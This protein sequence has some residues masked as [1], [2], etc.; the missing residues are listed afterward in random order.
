MRRVCA[1]SPQ[2]WVQ[3]QIQGLVQGWVQGSGSGVGPGVGHRGSDLTV[4]TKQGDQGS[5]GSVDPPPN[6]WTGILSGGS[7]FLV[8]FRLKLDSGS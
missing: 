4:K 5:R 1:G 6:N 8:T 2:G 3:G 7:D